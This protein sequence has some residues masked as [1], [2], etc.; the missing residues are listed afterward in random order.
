MPRQ[1]GGGNA[2]RARLSRADRFDLRPDIVGNRTGA[3]PTLTRLAPRIWQQEV[4]NGSISGFVYHNRRAATRHH[5]Q[6]PADILVVRQVAVWQVAKCRSSCTAKSSGSNP[7]MNVAGIL[8]RD[9]AAFMERGPLADRIVTAFET[10]PEQLQTAA[11]YVL[12]RPRDVALLSMREQARRAGVQPATMTR[13]AQRLGLNGYEAIRELY[14]DAIRQDGLGFAGRAGLQ[15]AS[16]KLK[17]ERALAA[18]MFDSLTNQIAKLAHSDVIEP[19]I[20]AAALLA[21]ADRIYCLGL[22]A[23]HAIAWQT[24]YVL[25][26]LGDR[27]ML[28]DGIAG[29]GR[30]AIRSA[31]SKDALFAVSI[32]PYTRAT[33]EAAQYANERGVPI[34]ALTDSAV[35]PLAREARHTILVPTEGPSFFHS[36]TPAF[37]IG[38]ILTAIVAGLGGEASLAALR[39]TETQ[40]AAFQ[41]HWSQGW[42]AA[43][44]RP[45]P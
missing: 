42:R 6:Q 39:Q 17:G 26:L 15:V 19:L 27:A 9:Y 33:I 12:A 20:A 16:Q 41:V 35:S 38:E 25:S 30:D 45:L 4:P 2:R 24:Y 43:R 22:R 40:L 34:V 14:A 8:T 13:L 44:C 1:P 31:T 3:I 32:E 29:I 36:L 28:L 11:R 23:C 7:E 37:V 5:V 21:S 10:M 18:E